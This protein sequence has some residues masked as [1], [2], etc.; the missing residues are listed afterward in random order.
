[1]HSA[2]LRKF[3]A[4]AGIRKLLLNT[5]TVQLI[6]GNTWE[7]RFWGVDPPGSQ[8][9]ENNLGKILMQVRAELRS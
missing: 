8:N 6:E 3:K 9:G 7:D 4:N 2:V 5:G 1:M